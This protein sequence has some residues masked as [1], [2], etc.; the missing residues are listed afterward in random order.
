M[1]CRVCQKAE[2]LAQH[3]VL[4]VCEKCA[5]SMA[6]AAL[7]PL[8]R[9]ARPCRMCDGRTFVR[10][11]PREYWSG[12][13]DYVE[14][15]VAPMY[16]VQAPSTAKTFWGSERLAPPTPAGTSWGLMEMFVCR[17][18]DAVEWYCHDAAKIPIGAAYNTE[19]V[20][21]PAEGTYR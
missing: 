13:G 2:V 16:A 18:C 20:E 5:E 17:A 6:V 19:L 21:Y 15:R 11:V 8:K 9:P 10:V 12:G 3:H 14:Q 1:I 7:P 4:G